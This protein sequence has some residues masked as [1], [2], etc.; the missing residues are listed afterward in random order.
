MANSFGHNGHRKASS[1]KFTE[2]AR[3]VQNRQFILD[4]IYINTNIIIKSLKMCYLQYDVSRFCC[5]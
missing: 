2:L 5:G 1:Q 3:I 4:P